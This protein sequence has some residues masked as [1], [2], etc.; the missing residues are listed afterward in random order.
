[1]YR[2][3]ILITLFL[4]GWTGLPWS[5]NDGRVVAE[6]AQHEPTWWEKR[7]KRSDIYYPHKAHFA[8]MEEEGDSCLLCH[9]FGPNTRRDKQNLKPLTTI[10]NEPLKAVCHNCHVDERRGPWRCE[11]CHDDRTKIWPA[12]HNFSYIDHHGEAGRR[13][14]AACRDCHL[15]LSFCTNCHFR[16]DTAGQGYH[17]LGYRSLHGLEARIDTLSCGRCHNTPYCDECHRVSR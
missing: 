7:D 8:V 16:R 10:A 4:L 15:D 17:P 5:A 1:M 13:D 6:E 14:E 2:A 3:L 9:G 11:L 12:D